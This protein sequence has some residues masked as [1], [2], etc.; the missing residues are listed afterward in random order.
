MKEVP[1]CLEG[2]RGL[3]GRK[4]SLLAAFISL[5]VVGATI[6][7]PAIV[8]SVALDASSALLAAVF[9]GAGAGAIV[10]GFGHLVSALI[11]GMPMGPLHF[12]V[13][14]E[15]AAL[16]FLFAKMWKNK[17][18]ASTM[19][20]IGNALLAPLPFIFF[21]DLAFYIALLPSLFV[22]ALFNTVVALILIPRL[23]SF[24]EGIYHKG[25]VK[26]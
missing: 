15:M 1:K 13:A 9:F 3:T 23:S 22:G 18:L 17:W 2:E 12:I 5:S 7:I 24:F 21:F 4:I 16:V 6:K 19:F 14:L 8:G 10:A 11:G 25:A 26:G 20:V